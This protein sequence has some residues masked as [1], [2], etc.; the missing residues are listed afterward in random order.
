MASKKREAFKKLTEDRLKEWIKCQ[1]SFE[2]FISNYIYLELPGG[3]VK[4]TPYDKQLELLRL[5]EDHHYAI[6][7]KSRQIGISTITQAY[8]CWLTVFHKNVV[9]G[10]VSKNGDAATKF[11]RFIAGFIDKLPKWM[12]PGFDKRNER[13]FVLNNGS[14][15]YNTPVDPK[16][17]GNCLRG[18]AV[19]F[20]ILDEAAFTQKLEDAWTSM[21][22]ALATSQKHAKAAGV[23][24]GT[25]IL[26]TPNKTT[27]M[28][29]F[30][31]SRY[32]KA[33]S[34]EGKLKSFI[35]H[36]KMI[37]ELA[38]DPDWYKTQCELF[39]NDPRRIQQELELKFLPTEGSFFDDKT[40]TILQDNP[41]DPIEVQKIFN[42]EI[43]VFQ[44]PIAGQ[45][46]LIGVDTATEN[47][48]DKSAIVIFD[49]VTMQQVWEYQAKC[50]VTDFCKIV[51]VAC[52]TYPGTIVI[53]NN[54]VGN[55]VMETMDRSVYH[56]M[57][58][59]EKRKNRKGEITGVVPGLCMDRQSRPLV[60][61][62]LYS[63]VSNYPTSIK[64]KS[65]ALELIGLITKKSGKVEADEGCHDDLA[66]ASS[67]C[68]YVR[69]YDPPMMINYKNSEEI[70]DFRNIMEMND[71][72]VDDMNNASIMKHIKH[73]MEKSDLAKQDEL[74]YVDIM[75]FYNE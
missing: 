54:S 42:G 35:I 63:Y 39:D 37:P 62:S 15:C 64:S 24:Y 30:F 8:V 47:G 26:S 74:S 49:Y 65:L 59:K 12:N 36:W 17:P 40:N 2:Y 1:K 18:E 71:I 13:S 61:D 75:E 52:A 46:Y 3:D 29:K 27:G 50:A 48:E 66:L 21:V 57:L 25:I 16:N 31:Y 44:R 45:H 22:P 7:L 34:G 67:M 4:I 56:T 53:E 14:K 55:Q 41:I 28:G 6:V 20:L 60:I 10:V 72:Y 32:L 11:S 73:K 43:R 68:Y 58:Y 5:V 69:K 33:I 19:T 23:P 51:K 9:V 70:N 38:D